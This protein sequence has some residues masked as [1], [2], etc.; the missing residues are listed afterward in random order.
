M[1]TTALPAFCVRTSSATRPKIF[2]PFT[3]C[4]D[5]TTTLAVGIPLFRSGH[6]HVYAID[7]EFPIEQEHGA[8]FAVMYRAATACLSY[9]DR[10]AHHGPVEF[11]WACYR[12]I[13]DGVTSERADR[14]VR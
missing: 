10:M 14:I 7:G 8:S 3:L 6:K 5:S 13:I 1:V 9:F 2:A 4:P 11:T 12:K